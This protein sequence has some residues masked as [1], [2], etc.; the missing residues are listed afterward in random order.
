VVLLG[1]DGLNVNDQQK[2]TDPASD[3]APIDT[4]VDMLE[5][6]HMSPTAPDTIQSYPFPDRDPFVLVRCSLSVCLSVCLCARCS[7]H[8]TLSPFLLLTLS[9]SHSAV[10]ASDV[11]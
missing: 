2:Y 9:I 3:R 6:S 10:G 7:Q 8:A 4:M 5:T 11:F 1:T